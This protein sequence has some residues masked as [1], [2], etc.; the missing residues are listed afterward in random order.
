MQRFKEFRVKAG[1]SI[2]AA[3]DKLN[4]SPTSIMHWEAGK[5]YP[6]GRTI[7]AMTQLYGCSADELLGL[8]K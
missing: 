3:A 5:R 1:L 7:V 6:N 2:L 8:R 4:V